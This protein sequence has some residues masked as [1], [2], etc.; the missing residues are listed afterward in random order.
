MS[1]QNYDPKTGKARIFFRFGG[2]QFNRTIKV[3]SKRGGLALCETV[4][5]TISDL[6]RGRLTLPPNSDPVSFILSGGKLVESQANKAPTKA[7]TLVE[8]FER[9]QAE[10]PPHLEASTRRMQ[11]TH[12][13]RLREVL[14]A[15]SI[16]AFSRATAQDYV[17]RRSKQQF[18]GKTIQAE[19]S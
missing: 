4:D 6:E 12:F 14:G 17:S 5:Q 1:S 2:R 7:V 9:Y 18:R 16:L 11:D 15:K 3:K 19:R 10:S 8:V 13:K